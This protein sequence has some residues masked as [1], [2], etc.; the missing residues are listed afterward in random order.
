MIGAGSEALNVSRHSSHQTAMGDSNSTFGTEAA[1]HGIETYFARQIELLEEARQ[2]VLSVDG[3]VS[4]AVTTLLFAAKDTGESILL[5]ARNRRMRDSYV[6][7]RVLFETLLNA[8]FIYAAGEETA[9]R[10]KRHAHQKVFRDLQRDLEIGG[11]RLVLNWTGD[12]QSVRTPELD[13]ALDEFTSRK[14]YEVRSWTPENLVERIEAV[15]AKYGGEASV[16]L[17]FGLFAIYRHASEIAHGT[18]FGSLFALG[19]A[20]PGPPPKG[21]DDIERHHREVLSM[22]LLIGGNV[23]ASLLAVVS[24]E[25]GT[26]ELLE[27][28]SAALSELG[29]APWASGA[30]G[31]DQP[32][33][34]ARV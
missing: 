26:R 1:L 9:L 20:S 32:G 18:V 24:L 15:K 12:P 4:A 17:E 13:A 7:S 31:E 28:A 19:V 11:Q 6:L 10:A 16:G 21:P 3:E 25:L 33:G 14:G 22:I 2:R 5:L 29:K 27:Q 23:I 30:R 34:E 8:C